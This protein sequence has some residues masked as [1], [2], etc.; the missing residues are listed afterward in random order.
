MPYN[1]LTEKKGVEMI[2]NKNLIKKLATTAIYLG[3]AG[4]VSTNVVY[5]MDFGK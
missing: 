2:K 1:F 5:G 4:A 3:I